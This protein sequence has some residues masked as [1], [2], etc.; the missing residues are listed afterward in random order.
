LLAHFFVCLVVCV[1]LRLHAQSPPTR[2]NVLRIGLLTAVSASPHST[3]VE[4]GVQ[5]GV[6]EAKRTAGLFGND[7]ELYEA[8]AGAD[9]AASAT[10]L[11]SERKVDVLIGT[12][13]AD[14]EALSKLAEQRH[15]VFL[16][17]ASRARTLRAACRRYTLHVEASEAMYASATLMSTGAPGLGSTRV[18]TVDS[19]VLWAPTLERYG[20]AQINDRYRAKYRVGMDG[21]AWAG[22]VAVKIAS[23]SALRARSSEPARLL[24]YLASP[25]TTF[26][27]H[28]GWPLS[29]RVADHQ[30]RQPLYVVTD[31][32]TASP[33]VRDVPEL[34]ASSPQ[35]SQ[36]ESARLNQALDRL[37]AS[38]TAPGCHWN[39]R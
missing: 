38:P 29:F 34:R 21:G 9:A 23:E 30:L 27:G 39:K 35:A 20:A 28:K 8:G 10:R 6:A 12:S 14:A 32:G 3:S 36:G 18:A 2:A 13:P 31:A 26:D 1:A 7:V 17:V 15:I 19:V 25:S 37:T 11:S 22:W 16:N 4:R 33:A 5:L 24:A